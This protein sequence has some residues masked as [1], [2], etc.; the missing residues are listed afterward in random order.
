MTLQKIKPIKHYVCQLLEMPQTQWIRT[1]YQGIRFLSRFLKVNNHYSSDKS[2]VNDIPPK[3]VQFKV[4]YDGR[5]GEAKRRA[6]RLQEA[7]VVEAQHN[8][9]GMDCGAPGDVRDGNGLLSSPREV[10]R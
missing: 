10:A 5:A 3:G 8:V 1:P 2:G 7:E 4:H 6:Q 9:V